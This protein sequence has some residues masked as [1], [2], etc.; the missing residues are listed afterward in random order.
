MQSSPPGHVGADAAVKICN[1]TVAGQT[2]VKE[3]RLVSFGH[4]GLCLLSASSDFTAFK[5]LLI[6]FR[7]KEKT[8]S[9]SFPNEN[10]E[11]RIFLFF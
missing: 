5:D 11:A 6:I 9:F 1:H 10:V 2:R 7:V 3:N 4:S 8:E